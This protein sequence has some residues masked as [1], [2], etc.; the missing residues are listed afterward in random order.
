MRYQVIALTVALLLGLVPLSAQSVFLLKGTVSDEEGLPLEECYVSNPGSIIA[1]EMQRHIVSAAAV[2]DE[3]KVITLY[4]QMGKA[5]EIYPY[6]I[7]FGD[8]TGN[9]V[10]KKEAKKVFR[11]IRKQPAD[12]VRFEGFDL[13]SVW[14]MADD[15]AAKQA[16]DAVKSAGLHDYGKRDTPV[17]CFERKE[18]F[19]R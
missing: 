11:S 14:N 1:G 4:T 13:V 8:E 7:L 9:S 18:Y 6:V 12:S 19:N 10:Y 3:V 5:G 2:P 15:P 17:Y 16:A